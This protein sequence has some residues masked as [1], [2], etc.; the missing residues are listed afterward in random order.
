[1]RRAMELALEDAGLTPEAIGYVNGHGT[2][3]EQGDIAETRA[4]AALFGE[5][6]AD[7]FAE[8]LSRPHPRRLRCARSPGS[9]SK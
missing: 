3:T 6:H 2:A 4:T 8:E 7:Q 9:A 1:M 5:Q